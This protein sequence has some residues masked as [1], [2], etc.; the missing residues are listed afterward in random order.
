MIFLTLIKFSI[1]LPQTFFSLCS[2]ALKNDTVE[3]FSAQ[4]ARDLSVMGVMNEIPGRKAAL[5]SP[6]LLAYALDSVECGLTFRLNSDINLL[7]KGSLYFSRL[8]SGI[9]LRL[10]EINSI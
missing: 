1:L 4:V 5:G 7:T 8:L 10:R 3:D 2:C 9:C 6:R